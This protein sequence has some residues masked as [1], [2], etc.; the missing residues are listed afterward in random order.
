M[1]FFR[2][3][4]PRQYC[5]NTITQYLH[6]VHIFRITYIYITPNIFSMDV[7]KQAMH[8]FLNENISSG[9]HESNRS[10]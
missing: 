4:S 5:L 7:P 10:S 9:R 8:W 1:I 2:F 6:L 3:F